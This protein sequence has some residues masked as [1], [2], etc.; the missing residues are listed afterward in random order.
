MV[1]VLRVLVAVIVAVYA[2]WIAWPVL[3]PFSGAPFA[4]AWPTAVNLVRNVPAPHVAFWIV[5]ILFYLV[6][7]LLT[8]IGSGRAAVIFLIGFL[9][10]ILLRLSIDQH[11]P[12]GPADIHQRANEGLE[13][14]GLG[15]DPVP[16]TLA[17]VAILG[18]VVYALDLRIVCA[19]DQRREKPG[20]RRP[21]PERRSRHR[22]G[23]ERLATDQMDG[24][25]AAEAAPAPS[26]IS[27]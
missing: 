14:L 17:A 25:P 21:G 7:S 20:G 2:G 5:S 18:L 15:V 10:E 27:G 16:L 23:P 3:A 1:W 6:A 12:G 13:P 24:G 8:L 11:G 19:P 26:A 22:T 4:E 9:T